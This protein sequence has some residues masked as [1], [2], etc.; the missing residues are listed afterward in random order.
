MDPITAAILAAIGS[1]ALTAV[2]KIG[3]D[4]VSSAYQKLKGLLR[5]K[6]GGNHMVEATID[7]AEAHPDSAAR[8][9]M[10][11]EVLLEA[12]APDDREL[13][14]AAEAL[15]AVIKELPSGDQIVTSVTN[16]SNVA[17]STRTGTASVNVGI[18][19]SNTGP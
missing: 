3:E 10:L 7:D 11:E 12:K 19:T 15:L 4:S 1:C 18:P 6:F 14:S 16:S 8:K 5:R 17:I 9:A 2:G 13:V